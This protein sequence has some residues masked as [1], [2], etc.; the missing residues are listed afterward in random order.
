[1]TKAKRKK[2]KKEITEGSNLKE[3]KVEVQIEEKEQEIKQPTKKE[4]LE[5]KI[6][7][8]EDKLLRQTAE[9]DNYK[10][11]TSRQYD[12]MVRYAGENVIT[13]LLEIADNF[14]RA[15]EHNDENSNFESFR[16]GINLIYNQMSRLL[17]KYGVQPIE[18]IGKRFDP[19]LHEALMQVE[20][21]EY[22]EGIIALEIMKGYKMGDKV[23]RHS[24]VGVARSVNKE[25]KD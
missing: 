5:S 11:R 16:E 1:M 18:T 22:N 4:M 3:G 10:K 6:A 13:E 8:L 15:M 12:E 25:N 7:E 21:D 19:N 9:F 24:K 20:S 23:I 2:D 14:N 17:D